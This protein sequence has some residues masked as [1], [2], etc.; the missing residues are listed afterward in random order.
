MRKSRGQAWA[1]EGK[2]L[3][4]VVEAEAERSWRWQ[5]TSL[6]EAWDDRGTDW[7]G[8]DEYRGALTVPEPGDW[9]FAIRASFVGQGWTYCDQGPQAGYQDAEAGAL[10]ALPFVEPRL[11]INEV[12]YDQDGGDIAEFIELY[13]PGPARL[14]LADLALEFVNGATN[15]VYLSQ[16][17]SEAGEVLEAD[18]YLVVGSP[19]VTDLM[20]DHV[21]TM[22][23]LSAIQNGG[24]SP[25][26]VRVISRE[27][28]T[29]DALSYEGA[30]QSIMGFTEGEGVIDGDEPSISPQGSLSR[31]PSGADTD[32]NRADFT[33]AAQS[34]PGAVNL[35][36]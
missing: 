21:L 28:V 16:D 34:T 9:R 10:N 11:L 14:I 30:G 31:C 25:D 12:D 33:L 35:C 20:P 13:N 29:Y 15:E 23:L 36:P 19:L 5:A 8:Y 2:L 7:V 4:V 24:N 22:E 32:Q 1:E 27:S 6:A 17:L 3:E 18:S 26:G